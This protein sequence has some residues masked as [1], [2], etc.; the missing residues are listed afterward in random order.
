MATKKTDFQADLTARYPTA[1][2]TAPLVAAGIKEGEAAVTRARGE[3]ISSLTGLEVSKTIAGQ[4][5]EAG[6]GYLESSLESQVKQTVD[7]YEAR[8]KTD[9]AQLALDLFEDK[10]MP[11]TPAEVEKAK[12]DIQK[13]RNALDQGIMTREQALLAIDKSVKDYSNRMPGWASDFRKL[14][15]NLTGI[16]HVGRY[17]EH[18]LLTTQS[19]AERY[20]EQQMDFIRK[21]QQKAIENF[22]QTYGRLPEGGWNGVDMS[23]FRD[24]LALRANADKLKDQLSIRDSTVAQNEPVALEYINHRL[25][26]GLITLNTR[27]QGL[28]YS[29]DPK[30]GK[31]YGS[32]NKIII[33]Q[34]V[35]ADIGT[36]FETLK[37]E[38]LGFNT[39]QLSQAAREQQLNRLNTQ[40]EQLTTALR[41]Q[42]SFDDFRKNMELRASL[43]KD[44]INKWA[45]ANPH[46]EII[47]QSGMATPEIARVWF[48]FQADPKRQAE[49]RRRYGGALDD[50]FRSLSMGGQ[51]LQDRHASDMSKSSVSEE[52]INA[53]KLT[54]DGAYRAAMHTLR[55]HIKD[56]AIKGWG[57]SQ[58][59]Q[60]LRK[61]RFADNLRVFGSQIDFRD[62][63]AVKSWVQLMSDGR[64]AERV[65]DLPPNLQA[66]AIDSVITKARDV[67]E[68]SEFGAMKRLTT[69]QKSLGDSTILGTLSSATHGPFELVYDDKSGQI[70]VQQYSRF[71][72]GKTQSRKEYTVKRDEKGTATELEEKPILTDGGSLGFGEVKELVALAN[73]ALSVLKTF[74]QEERDLASD[75]VQ[76]FNAGYFGM[77]PEEREKAL[78]S[79]ADVAAKGKGKP[80]SKE[81]KLSAINKA[82]SK[83]VSEQLG[84]VS[85]EEQSERDALAGKVR[86]GEVNND[87]A[88]IEAHLKDIAT[89]LARKDLNSTARAILK[90]EY[91]LWEKAKEALSGQTGN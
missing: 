54:N 29:K 41:N 12:A 42:D 32:E 68:N 74:G 75:T 47:R 3:A 86:A 50:Y 63:S 36:F 16:E 17:R 61:M 15:Y 81:E 90:K 87:P 19:A 24:Q 37:S 73:R 49:F 51:P 4:V 85:P 66:I 14:A 72:G 77:A 10:V 1:P 76:K 82:E 34:N 45:I 20:R 80:S 31:P 88:V 44:V 18:S 59:T 28:V 56:I 7:S 52:H 79:G 21:M 53:L 35:L 83:E 55:D 27:L 65:Q 58:E 71:F 26:D 46:L 38:V 25:S 2:D 69:L 43:A 84:S 11:S 9:N 6:K 89:E 30:T 5:V 60:E 70:K 39:N 67:V 22:V 8:V 33:R 13:Y 23:L 62:D 64:V 91:D 57:D 48:D 78:Q 40:Q